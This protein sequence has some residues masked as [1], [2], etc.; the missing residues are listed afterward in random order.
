[1]L[2]RSLLLFSCL[3]FFNA[4]GIE[5]V[6]GQERP[7]ETIYESATQKFRF[8]LLT[9]RK[10]VIW[11]FDFL[12]DNRI[13]FTERGGAVGILDLKNKSVT[14]LQGT[15]E[16][17]VSGQG[18]MLDV[19]A[20]PS[21]PR[22]IYLTYSEPV[23]RGGTTAFAS[24]T[25]EG[26]RLVD[27][28]KH[29]SAHE[30]NSE[31]IHFGSRIEF[32]GKGHVFVTVGDRDQRKRAQDL[33]YHQGKVLR[34]HEDGSVPMDNPFVNKS[35]AKPEIWSYGHRSPQ[36]LVRHPVTGELWLAEMGPRGGDELNLIKP[37][38]NYGWPVATYGKEYWGPSIGATAAPGTEPP[39]AYWV[40][41]ISPSG[42]TFY[43][44]SVFP[45]WKGNA[46]L[47]NLSGMHLRRLVVEGHK[48]VSQEPLFEGQGIRFRNVRPGSDGFLYVST[49]DGRIARLV[50]AR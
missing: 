42:M 41:S 29:F 30:P 25:L 26:N 44:G 11:G 39:V 19:R 10:D 35:G 9:Q 4:T 45:K 5:R 3:S 22:K 48:I 37:G 17:W 27:F 20:H 46:F 40:P 43:N 14:L 38:A 6:Y 34:F 28:K 32:D 24:A 1:M 15:P 50:P 8:E 7:P 31:S 18:G 49:D 33:G 47:A 21:N 2:F 13:V 12:P 16:V 36:G 23:G